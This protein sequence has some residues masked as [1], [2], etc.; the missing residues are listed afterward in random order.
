[1]RKYLFQ[2]MVEVSD[3]VG[4]AKAR[5]H[6]VR[7]ITKEPIEITPVGERCRFGKVIGV[8]AVRLDLKR[9]NNQG[10]VLGDYIDRS[11]KR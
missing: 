3:N 10:I 4:F 8:E 6:V 1:M 11:K 7:S 2:V 9:R 5:E